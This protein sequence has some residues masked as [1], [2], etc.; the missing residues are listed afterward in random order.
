M[1][2][3]AKAAE[4][5]SGTDDFGVALRKSWAQGKGRWREEAEASVDS[6]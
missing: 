4:R 1:G 6:K 2:S 3:S 5:L